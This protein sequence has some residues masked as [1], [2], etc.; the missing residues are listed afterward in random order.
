MQTTLETKRGPTI[1]VVGL[2]TI[3]QVT[4]M[5]TTVLQLDGI[6]AE[7][8]ITTLIM[9]RSSRRMR[10]RTTRPEAGTSASHSCAIE[11]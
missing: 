7:A 1:R 11:T 10:S 2:P 8:M 9:G 4:S 6:E 5:E 3:T